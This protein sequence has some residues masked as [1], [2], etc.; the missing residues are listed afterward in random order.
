MSNLKSQNQN[1]NLKSNIKFRT[2]PFF[3]LII[4]FNSKPPNN[5]IF[6]VMS[7]Q[8]LKAATSISAN[9]IEAKLSSSKKDFIKSYEIALKYANE[10]RYWLS[11][12]K[13]CNLLTNNEK[14]IFLLKESEEITN[15][16]SSSF[17]TLKG[18]KLIN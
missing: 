2:Y 9:I 7:D 12:L 18:K 14:I 1:L 16:V 8:L 4:N 5:R 10:T 15:M 3:L 17:L 11:L 6:W 13:E